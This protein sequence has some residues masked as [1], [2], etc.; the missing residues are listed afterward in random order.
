MFVHH[1]MYNHK[2]TIP[3]NK[4]GIYIMIHYTLCDCIVVLVQFTR[5]HQMNKFT[6]I[7]LTLT[8]ILIVETF[9][10]IVSVVVYIIIMVKFTF[11][12]WIKN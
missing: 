1:I 2:P 6:D 12:C 7:C 11:R 8:I 4:C 9:G 3:N 5:E 10:L